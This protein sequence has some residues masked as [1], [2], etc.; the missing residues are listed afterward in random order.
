MF[1]HLYELHDQV[2]FFRQIVLLYQG[3]DILV[4]HSPQDVHFTVY[5]L[6][7]PAAP[8]L[9]DDFQRELTACLSGTT[10]KNI[11]ITTALYYNAEMFLNI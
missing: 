9:V 2:E 8:R 1:A 11:K 6:L 10:Q 4:L 3:D 7:T 5:H